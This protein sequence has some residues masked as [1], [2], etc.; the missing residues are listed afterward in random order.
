MSINEKTANDDPLQERLM[1][2]WR[3]E[4]LRVHAK[5]LAWALLFLPP[6]LLVL[7]GLDRMLDLPRMGRWSFLLL[8]LA[9]FVWQGRKRWFRL[10][11]IRC[12]S[13]GQSGGKH[14][15]QMGSLLINY[16][17]IVSPIPKASGSQELLGLVSQQASKRPVPL[18]FPNRLISRT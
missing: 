3:R 9:L 5:G 17:Q 14:F 6:L 1:R 12:P 15:P 13:L 8:A 16:V 7:F 18:I 4:R 11:T 2:P 10:E